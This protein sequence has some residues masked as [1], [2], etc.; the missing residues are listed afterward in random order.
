MLASSFIIGGINALKNAD[1]MADRAE[2][3]T[4]KLEPMID[5]ASPV[6]LKLTSKQMVIAN[7]LIH[8][9]AGSMLAMGKAPRLSAFALAATIV[10]TTFGG[11][12]FWEEPDPRARA[13]QQN[14]FMKNVSMTGGLILA[15]VDTEGKPSVAWRAKRTARKA[16]TAASDQVQHL[17]P[18]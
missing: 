11:H 3:V 17:T 9:V 2:P 18:G 1:A 6:P 15:A 13:N 8:V 14:H 5:K 7:G 4:D 10:P 12:R 16:A